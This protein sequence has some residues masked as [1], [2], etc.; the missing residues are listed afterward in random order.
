[1]PGVLDN[2]VLLNVCWGA[3]HIFRSLQ[4]IYH[5]LYDPCFTD[6]AMKITAPLAL[7]KIHK[8]IINYYFR[9]NDL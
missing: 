7:G 4:V 9:S 3:V 6:V 5:Y 2:G 1:M 8:S